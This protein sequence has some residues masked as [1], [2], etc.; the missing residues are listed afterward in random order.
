MIQRPA[1]DVAGIR[2]AGEDDF[3]EVLFDRAGTP[4]GRFRM[5][6]G[7][8]WRPATNVWETP[9]E[10]VVQADLAGLG[11]EAIEVWT[12]GPRLLIRG[13]RPD[14]G[15]SGRTHFHKLEIPSGPFERWISLPDRVDATRATARYRHGFLLVTI[16]FGD[17]VSEGRRVIDIET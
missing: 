3:F 15:R 7:I 14:P 17:Q 12:D 5:E 11:P 10:L 1:P 8:G 6:A 13:T 16:P 9:E 2:A 4:S